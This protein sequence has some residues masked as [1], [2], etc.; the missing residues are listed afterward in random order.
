MKARDNPFSAERVLRV[1]YRLGGGTAFAWPQ[2]WSRLENLRF[3]AAIVGPRGSGKTTLIEDLADFLS[4]QGF[5]PRPLRL[6]EEE[7]ALRPAIL[8]RLRDEIAARDFVL[9]DGAEQLGW[10]AW[11]RFTAATRRAGGLVITRH[12]PGGLPTLLECRT[13]PRLLE[14]IV[15]ELLGDETPLA[16]LRLPELYR[17]HDGNLREALRELYDRFAAGG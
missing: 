6:D 2:L 10:I 5:R 4:D 11:R 15:T 7:P 8:R 14:G 9:L 16:A 12:R 13:T 1:R 17:R 3:R